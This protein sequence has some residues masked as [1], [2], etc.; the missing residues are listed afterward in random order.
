MHDREGQGRRLHTRAICL[1]AD[2]LGGSNCLAL[3]I[4]CTD[5]VCLLRCSVK[6]EWR[7]YPGECRS[8]VLCF[9]AIR[10]RP[11][12]GM[13]VCSLLFSFGGI[14]CVFV[15]NWGHPSPDRD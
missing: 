5:T 15:G 11:V 6:Y 7:G 9:L 1:R 2:E 13:F 3:Q 14:L 12:R 4:A 8:L 10:A